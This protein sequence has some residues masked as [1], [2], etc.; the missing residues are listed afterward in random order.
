VDRERLQ[1]VVDL[2]TIVSLVGAGAL[3]LYRLANPPQP[4]NSGPGIQAVDESSAA[5]GLPVLWL[6]CAGLVLLALVGVAVRI[7]LSRKH[8][9]PQGPRADGRRT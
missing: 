2:S 5:A 3:G 8:P 1:L 6:G 4:A 7:Y 9:V